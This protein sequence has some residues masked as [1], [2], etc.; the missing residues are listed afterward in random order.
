MMKLRAASR[1][2]HNPVVDSEARASGCTPPSSSMHDSSID[3]VPLLRNEDEAAK[4]Y[5]PATFITAEDC[6]KRKKRLIQ[7][8]ERLEYRLEYY[9]PDCFGDEIE[10]LFEIY[11]LKALIGYYESSDLGGGDEERSLREVLVS[12]PIE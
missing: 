5:I 9:E 12:P 1:D 3:S 6:T 11:R 2:S 7:R 10:M 4:R 8:L